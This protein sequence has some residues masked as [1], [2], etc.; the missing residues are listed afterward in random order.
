[1][2][3]QKSTFFALLK[4][5]KK[6]LKINNKIGSLLFLQMAGS[7]QRGATLGANKQR[8]TNS[9]RTH[10]HTHTG[11]GMVRVYAGC[12]PDANVLTE[13]TCR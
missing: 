6:S 7:T 11:P 1:M 9:A 10:A 13:Q 2:A 4:M 12:E 5:H 8:D 3:G